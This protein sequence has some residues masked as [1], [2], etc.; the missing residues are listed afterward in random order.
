MNV[1]ANQ[2]PKLSEFPKMYKN[3]AIPHTKF[4]KRP[5]STLKRPKSNLLKLISQIS[6]KEQQKMILESPFAKIAITSKYLVSEIEDSELFCSCGAGF[7]HLD[8]DHN[9]LFSGYEKTGIG[10]PSLEVSY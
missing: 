6:I 5:S 8:H 9:L 2:T 4:K 3:Y 7:A 10:P 1:S